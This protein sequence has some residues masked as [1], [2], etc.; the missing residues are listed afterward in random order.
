[1]G[2]TVMSITTWQFRKY[3]SDRTRS[4]CSFS[5]GF[6]PEYK[7]F[8]AVISDFFYH[9]LTFCIFVLFIIYCARCVQSS[10]EFQGGFGVL[11]IFP[12]KMYPSSANGVWADYF[13]H[14][15]LVVNFKFSYIFNEITHLKAWTGAYFCS[16]TISSPLHCPKRALQ[17]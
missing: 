7:Q 5:G 3:R 14:I 1:M 11:G 4:C 17:L 12:L 13:F 2:I 8:V 15:F 6:N 16:P 10:S 9:F